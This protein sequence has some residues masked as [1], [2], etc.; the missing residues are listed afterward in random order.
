MLT[1]PSIAASIDAMSGSSTI[2]SNPIRIGH[3]VASVREGITTTPSGTEQPGDATCL[4]TG[5]LVHP[6]FFSSMR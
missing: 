1:T 4:P 3:A 5:N 6:M 2:E